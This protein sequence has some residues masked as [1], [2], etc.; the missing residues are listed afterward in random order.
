MVSVTRQTSTKTSTHTKDLDLIHIQRTEWDQ[1][2][3]MFAGDFPLLM[4]KTMNGHVDRLN[5]L[6]KYVTQKGITLEDFTQRHFSAYLTYRKPSVSRRTMQLDAKAAKKFTKW[7]SS[8]HVGLLDRDP[9]RDYAVEKPPKRKMPVP[10]P[11]HM[12]SLLKAVEACWSP[13]QTPNIRYYPQRHRTFYQKQH[14][15]I[16][17]VLMATACRIDVEVLDLRLIDVDQSRLQLTVGA[18]KGDE[19]RTVFMSK[20]CLDAIKE[21]LNQR[22]KCESPYLFINRFGGRLDYNRFGKRF[23]DYRKRAGLEWITLHRI[24]AFALTQLAMVDPLM[25]QQQAGHKNLNTTMIYVHAT[26]EHN[27]EK[28]AEADPLGSVLKKKA[29]QGK[30]VS[31]I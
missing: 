11:E 4:T 5:Q 18:G 21:W 6:V 12:A 23:R 27:R 19:G 20:T 31:L 30:R 26:Q 15:A 13:A 17:C 16:L 24:R 3:Q 8:A 22:P 14:R 10:S 1:A 7:A 25:A 29:K 28:Y 9:L 2:V